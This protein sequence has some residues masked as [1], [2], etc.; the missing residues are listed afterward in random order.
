MLIFKTRKMVFTDATKRLEE[1]GE[2]ML[3]WQVLAVLVRDGKRTQGEIAAGLAQHPAGVSRLVDDLE[4]QGY[5]ERAR[6]SAD[7]RRVHVEATA[8]GERRFRSILPEVIGAVDHVLEP[9]SENERRSLRDLLRK[10]VFQDS[11]CK[12]PL[13]DGGAGR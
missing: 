3:A 1:F 8:K 12:N 4:K 2:S 5:V 6:D 11:E 9:L 7:R 13:R 10:V